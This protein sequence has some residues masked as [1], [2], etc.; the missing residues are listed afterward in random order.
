MK[1][2]TR[3]HEYW[4]VGIVVV[5]SAIFYVT[6]G[7][8]YLVSYQNSDI[9]IHLDRVLGLGGVWF[10]PVNF[11]TFAQ[12]GDGINYFYPW[13]TLY[14]AYILVRLTHSLVIGMGIFIIWINILTGLIAYYSSKSIFYDKLVA[15]TF[16]I[17]YI[18]TTYRS[19]DL[20]RRFDIGEFIA[21]AFIPLMI[22]ALYQIIVCDKQRWMM[23]A[24]AMALILYSHLLSLVL[25]GVAGALEV[26]AL[27][28][29]SK[30]KWGSV[31]QLIKAVILWFLLGLGFLIPCIQQK[32]LGVAMPFKA[33][34]PNMAL[35]VK[36]MIVNGL[37]NSLG[38]NRDI[39]VSL[40]VLCTLICVTGLFLQK[41]SR[42]EWRF[43]I[44]GI[45]LALMMTKLFPWKLFGHLPDFIQFPWR[46]GEVAVIFLLLFGVSWLLR[47]KHSYAI[48]GGLI[49]ASLCSFVIRTQRLNAYANSSIIVTSSQNLCNPPKLFLPV[50][51]QLQ[52][53]VLNETGIVQHNFMDGKDNTQPEIEITPSQVMVVPKFTTSELDTPF[54]AY[55]GV[56]A[57]EPSGKVLSSGVSF[58]DTLL[59]K[60]VKRGGHIVVTSRYTLAARIAQWISLITL[61]GCLWFWVKNRR[62]MLY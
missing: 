29:F 9:I 43:L 2:D 31:K 34:L 45:V 16:S 3:K 26:I 25:C 6:L 47:R 62:R 53:A 60:H 40:G 28:S 30:N 44:V 35:P 48:A 58:R 49:I 4:I 27:Y 14:P 32:Q 10:H 1:F 55:K 61:I 20:Y 46:F 21:M 42:V 5:L 12:I 13:L 36:Q 41:K 54:E 24:I 38:N 23:L 56:F 18:F 8:H 17:L 59:I 22:S 51:Y 33:W 37:S 7:G 50:D 15:L 52:K 39:I 11:K 19:L 57:K